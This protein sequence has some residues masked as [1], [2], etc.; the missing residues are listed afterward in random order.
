MGHNVFVSYKYNDN[1]VAWLNGYTNY[2][3]KARDYAY[4][5]EYNLNKY[6][7]N[8]YLGERDG[9]DLSDKS[10]DYIWEHLKDRIYLSTVTIVLITPN[11]REQSRWEKSQWIPWEV[12]Y[13]LRETTRNDK[14]SRSN[15]ILA[16]VL[17]DRYG[18]Y[19]YYNSM[20]LFNILKKNIDNGY[21]NVVSWNYF[22]NYYDLC[23]KKAFESKFT[24][25][26]NLLS[27]G[28]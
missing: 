23:I 2:T 14:T 8:N 13:S 12:S 11:M 24:I 27:I 19:N 28:L 15:A 17:P 21:I 20:I 4:W 18:S 3:P 7:D 26:R 1:N 25:R 10:E 16:V 9:E 6:S 5:I 22:A